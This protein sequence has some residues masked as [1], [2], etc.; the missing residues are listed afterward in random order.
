[1]VERRL[2]RLARNVLKKLRV[3]NAH[4]AVFLLE[5][6]K[7]RHLKVKYLKK[8]PEKDPD[9]LAFRE[10]AGFPHP[11]TKK[12]LLGEVY[13]NAGIAKRDPGLAGRLLVHGLLHLLD[14]THN[15]KSDTL[16]MQKKEAKLLAKIQK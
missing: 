8:R 6:R 14:Y 1:M 13:I 11:E 9:V 3:R 4:A 16:R 12:R 7:M 5:G 15:G 10:P 2:A